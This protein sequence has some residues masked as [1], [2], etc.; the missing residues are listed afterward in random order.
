VAEDYNVT[1]GEKMQ[2][3]TAAEKRLGGE[4]NNERE[5]FRKE[6]AKLEF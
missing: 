2:T 6:K 3:K 1:G 5:V 4:G